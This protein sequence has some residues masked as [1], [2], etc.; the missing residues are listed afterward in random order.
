MR[1]DQISTRE[2]QPFEQTGDC[3]GGA[4][5]RRPVEV[6][7]AV[8]GVHHTRI[9][10]KYDWMPGFQREMALQRF[11]QVDATAGKIH[12]PVSDEDVVIALRVEF[13]ELQVLRTPKPSYMRRK[14]PPGSRLPR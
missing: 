4:P 2:A 9:S 7:Q 12:P 5:Q 1:I 8:D 14:P 10:W 3:Q 11:D 13:T 6:T